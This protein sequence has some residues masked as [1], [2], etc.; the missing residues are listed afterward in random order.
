MR[1]ISR[2]I[3][4]GGEVLKTLAYGQ[5]RKVEEYSKG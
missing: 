1:F 5:S 3:V 4:E 2:S